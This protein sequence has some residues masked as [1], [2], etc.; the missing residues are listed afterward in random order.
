MPAAKAA[1]ITITEVRAITN[2]RSGT[3]L[4]AVNIAPD[5]DYYR[6]HLRHHGSPRFSMPAQTGIAARLR[7]KIGET[8]ISRGDNSFGGNRTLPPNNLYLSAASF[9]A[10]W[11]ESSTPLEQ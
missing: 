3:F 9:A 2:L 6:N 4:I 11:P 5:S 1:K 10:S 7:L 8:P